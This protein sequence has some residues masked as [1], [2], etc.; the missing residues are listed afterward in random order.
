MLGGIT[1]KIFKKL[2]LATC[3]TV[4]FLSAETSYVTAA[5]DTGVQATVV[6]GSLGECG[7]FIDFYF[8]SESQP[9]LRLTHARID[10]TGT[11]AEVDFFGSMCVAQ[12]QRIA[13]KTKLTDQIIEVDFV[14]FGPGECVRL[15]LDMDQL[16]WGSGTPLGT[17]Y[18]GGRVE[19]TFAGLPAPCANPLAG[20]F[21]ETDAFTAQASLSCAGQNVPAAPSNLQA[22]QIPDQ[23]HITWQDNSN[24]ETGFKLQRRI[25][26][27]AW[28]VVWTDLA[29][30]GRDVTSY[31]MD[32]PLVH[33]TYN[34]RVCAFN[35]Q[36]DSA[37][38]NVDSVSVEYIVFPRY[39]LIA[40]PQG[41][42]VWK[43]RTTQLIS[44]TNSATEPPSHVTLEYSTDGGSSWVAIPNAS[45]IPN[46]GSYLWLVPDTPS[47]KCLVRVL[48][49][50]GQLYDL[51]NKPFTI[52]PA[53]L[54]MVAHWKLD[55]SVGSIARDSAR[56]NHGT[57]FGVPTWRPSNG[58][59]GGALQFDGKDDFIEV[60]SEANF[61]ITNAITVA[62]WIKANAF[63]RDWQTIITKGDSAW[64][65]SRRLSS[66]TLYFACTGLTVN[67]KGR[68]CVNGSTNA[69]DG[70]WHHVVG[71]YDGSKLCLYVDGLLEATQSASG[72][73]QTNNYNV[74]IG[75]NPEAM[76][77]YWNGLIDDVRVY[78]YGL[79]PEEVLQLLCTQPP[80]GDLNGDCVV[81]FT[82]FAIFVSEWLT[83]SLAVNQRC[84]D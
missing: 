80:R 2:C 79:S 30:L 25:L 1:M 57:C 39:I 42:E 33:L 13:G 67:E 15:G 63:D 71:T 9:A 26:P 84:W 50:E 18:E 20:T 23:I 5:D 29:T 45:N 65:L 34:F 43:A 8:L 74:Y 3:L 70:Q 22:R 73:I 27:A 83:C 56:D 41:G 49:S 52:L 16:S 24:N 17:D 55:E 21:V 59:L 19:L 44:W 75:E 72:S 66:N 36:G 4:V 47:G 14:G 53:M 61:D 54:P 7:N 11:N 68:P 51:V 12:D 78:N 81:D 40:R 35:E 6:A 10:F 69:N 32:D 38:S 62:A 37:W 60:P 76:N 82:D 46:A 31:Q 77:R 64:T 48:D 58:Q 28:P